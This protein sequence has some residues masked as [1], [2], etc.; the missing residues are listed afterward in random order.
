[1]VI[2]PL[3]D[4]YVARTTNG[5]GAKDFKLSRG[6]CAL[7][8]VGYF[9]IGSS[10]HPVGLIF[11]LFIVALGSS[12]AVTLRSAVTSM[13]PP[14]L[15]G[16][17]YTGISVAYGLGGLTSGPAIAKVFLWGMAWGNAWLGLPFL[18]ASILHLTM[19]LA[20]SYAARIIRS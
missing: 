19:F 14:H 12:F 2:M 15:V 9:I 4:A 7:L 16:T 11:G 1:M 13:V 5:A 10:Q 3:V 18:L 8:A 17:L 20:V 6:S